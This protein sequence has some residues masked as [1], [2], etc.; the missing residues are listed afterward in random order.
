MDDLDILAME[1]D[2]VGSESTVSGPHVVEVED[3]IASEE[4]GEGSEYHETMSSRS[5]PS[6][7]ASLDVDLSS[8]AEELETLERDARAIVTLMKQMEEGEC[9]DKTEKALMQTT[10]RQL[11]ERKDSLTA[12][13]KEASQS[14]QRR[15]AVV[16]ALHTRQNVVGH[17]RRALALAGSSPGPALFGILCTLEE[18]NKRLAEAAESMV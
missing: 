2:G 8:L 18:G 13:Y 15:D 14:V 3:S 10:L 16:K 1:E 6:R 7:S 11:K 4:E 5:S 9:L 12:A 17:A